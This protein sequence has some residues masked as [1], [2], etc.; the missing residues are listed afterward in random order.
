MKVPIIQESVPRNRG[1]G[2]KGTVSAR[3]A[4]ALTG[5]VPRR[6]FG[7]FAAAGKVTPFPPP[8]RAEPSIKI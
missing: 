4:K 3:C 8:L 7:Y 2:G 6:R 5:A 1:T